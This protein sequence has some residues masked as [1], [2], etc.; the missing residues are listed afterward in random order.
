ME[1]TFLGTGSA[2]G[3]P[4]YNCPCLI[5]QAMRA[6]GEER[7]RT[8]FFLEA[9][10]NILIDPGMDLRRQMIDVGSPVP[11]AVIIT[12][13]H[14]DHMG[15][16]D[17]LLCFR[18]SLPKDDWRPIP[19]FAHPLAWPAIEARFGYL[20]GSL[21]TRGECRPGQPIPGL[22]TGVV[23]FKTDHGPVA[24]GSVGLVF[25]WQ[26]K[27]I[28]YTSDF[29]GLPH[30]PD[31]L[32]GADLLILQSHFF[33]Q[34]ANNRPHHMS[35]QRAVDYLDRWRPKRV[36]L[37]HLSASDWVPGDPA[38]NIL[39]KLEPAGP[40]TGPDGR[41]LPVPLTTDDWAELAPRVLAQA[42]L[43]IPVEPARE[44]MRLRV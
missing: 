43:D 18:R 36:V 13:E 15:G 35:L 23:P 24:Q 40:L 5:C 10:E 38:N 14:L 4:E 29:E 30:E 7:T 26:N 11:Q 31:I 37:V 8:S 42:G 2:W 12:H 32:A 21:L 34:P 16:L 6:G 20:M 39:Q 28:V 17:D 9:G 27:K 41:P 22:K 3:A 1:V 33:N 44:G 25:T 19:T